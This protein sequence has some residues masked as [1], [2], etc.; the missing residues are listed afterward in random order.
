MDEIVKAA[1]AKWPQVPACYG[2]L[3]LDARGT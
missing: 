2:W 3:G 1:M